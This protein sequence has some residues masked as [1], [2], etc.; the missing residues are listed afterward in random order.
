VTISRNSVL[1][2]IPAVHLSSSTFIQT[3][4]YPQSWAYL[5][6]NVASFPCV[7]DH[8]IE[9]L[10]RSE[11]GLASGTFNDHGTM[12]EIQIRE[13]LDTLRCRSSTQTCQRCSLKTGYQELTGG[14]YSTPFSYLDGRFI[15]F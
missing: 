10:S 15:I 2:D 12:Q 3:F 11:A 1:D 9:M 8:L 6:S 4:R 5:A 14:D 13:K 7:Q